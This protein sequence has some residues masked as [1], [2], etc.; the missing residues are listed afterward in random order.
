MDGLG[1]FFG[2]LFVFSDYRW[3]SEES[4]RHGK[5]KDTEISSWICAVNEYLWRKLKRNN[6]P[7]PQFLEIQMGRGWERWA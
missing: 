7:K 1:G 5:V 2:C 3:K 4:K 6:Y